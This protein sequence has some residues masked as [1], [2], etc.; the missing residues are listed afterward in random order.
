MRIGFFELESWEKAAIESRLAGNDLFLTGD[1]ITGMEIPGRRDFEAISVFVNSRIDAKVLDA[2]PSLRYVATR[3]TGYDHID[4]AECKKRGIAVSFVP[5][6]GDNTVAEFTFGLLVNLTRKIYQSI[7]RI[8]EAGSFNLSGLR[9]VDLAGKTLGVIGTGRIG[10]K[11]IKIAKG[12]EMNVIAY[13]PFPDEKSAAELGYQYVSFEDILKNSDI[14]TLHCLYNSQTRHM[15]NKGNISLLKKGA[16]LV[17]TARGGLVETEALVSALEQGILAGAALDVLEEEGE[18]R[19][20]IAHIA[21]GHPNE[22]ELKTILMNHAL[23]RMPNVLITPHN[24][25]N[26][27]EALMRILDMSLDNIDSFAK[28]E[29]INS[30]PELK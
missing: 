9:G 17:N 18:T 6:Y 7:D 10:K 21:K 12:F 1:G 4:I 25:F 23:M 24:A 16:Y 30:V 2:L 26:S 27:Q 28:G 15:I 14:L 3:S 20:E 8:K 19:E 13:D 22:E 11:M 5:G 29:M